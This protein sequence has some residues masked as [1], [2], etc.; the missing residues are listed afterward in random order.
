M[1]SGFGVRVADIDR[2]ALASVGASDVLA[3]DARAFGAPVRLRAEAPSSPYSFDAPAQPSTPRVAV[4]DVVGPVAQRGHVEG[5]CA[6]VDGYDTIAARLC[7]ALEDDDVDAVVIAFD[8]P[9]GDVA[10]MVEGIKRMRGAIAASG[11]P[12]VAY[13]DELAASAAYALATLAEEIIVP[14]SGQVG[15]IGT[16]SIHVDGSGALAKA[17]VAVTLI[18]SG[19]LKMV[20]SGSEPLSTDGRAVLEARVARTAQAFAELV[21]DARGKTAGEWLALEGALATGADAVRMGLADRVGSFEDAVNSASSR[22]EKNMG[23]KTTTPAAGL[24]AREEDAD[25]LAIGRATMAMLGASTTEEAMSKLGG[26][27]AI[28]SRAAEIEAA[29]EAAKVQAE[30]SERVELVR[31][32]VTRGALIPAR[33][34]AVGADGGP[35]PGAGVAE[36]WATMKIGHLRAA[37]SAISPSPA[38]RVHEPKADDSASVTERDKSAAA[39]IGVSVEAYVRGRRE[40]AAALTAGR[41][42][43]SAGEGEA[44]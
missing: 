8:S 22:A 17:G 23:V 1:R 34:W 42:A 39:S 35:S 24:S 21:A 28:A 13:V 32:M 4:V 14:A 15:S 27:Q 12:V 18:R 3:L 37:A 7:A 30:A 19:S 6:F 2:A 5:L 9:G 26:L 40:V 31:A 38:V 16:V 41:S 44:A 29:A 43:I 25:V 20:P 11:K 10:G 33:A 36:P